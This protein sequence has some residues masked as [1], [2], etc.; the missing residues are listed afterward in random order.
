M[1]S[2][3]LSVPRRPPGYYIGSFNRIVLI[4]E[5][6]ILLVGVSREDWSACQGRPVTEEAGSSAHSAL[7]LRL[8]Q[9]FPRV[10]RGM[11]RWQDR[12]AP[13]APAP[14]APP[15][16]SALEPLRGRP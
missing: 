9:L 10:S 12:P 8:M 4:A 7:C 14:L 2:S 11:R 16:A 5:P 1:R 3:V 13:P 6:Y 15:H